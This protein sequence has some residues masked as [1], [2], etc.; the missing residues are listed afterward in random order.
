MKTG[1]SF[2][3]SSRLSLQ[4]WISNEKIVGF[5]LIGIISSLVDIGLL[6]FFCSY[7]GIWYLTAAQFTTFAA[8]SVSCLF[9]NLCVIW[10]CVELFSL[11][12]LSGKII[13]TLCAFF[14]NYH[15]QKRYTFRG[16]N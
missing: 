6:V 10:L 1:G 13:A 15:G 14:W 11:D 7:L 12:Y 2:P 16:G 3:M 4:A 5:F 9:V 8:I